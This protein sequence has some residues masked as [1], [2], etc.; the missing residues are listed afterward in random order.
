MPAC[1]LAWAA[2]RRRS[3]QIVGTREPSSEKVGRP[4]WAFTGPR[5]LASVTQ[6]AMQRLDII[7]VGALSGL[8]DAA[9]YAA[10][11]RFLVL[12]G[13]VSGAV[14]TAVQPRL[15]EALGRSDHESARDLYATST[16]WLLMLSWP[17]YLMLIVFAPV[18]VRVFGEEYTSGAGALVIICASML[19]A[20]ACGTVD[21][22]LNM[23]G[24]TTWNLYNVI[25]AFAVNLSLDILLIPHLG[26]VGAAIGW[27]AAIVTANLVPLS[28]IHFVLHLHPFGSATRT[29]MAISLASFAV[30][31]VAA[32]LVIPSGLVAL[33]IAGLVGSCIYVV[34]LVVSRERLRLTELLRARGNQGGS[35][36]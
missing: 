6:L 23:A 29:A 8:K 9:I 11:T 5:A 31:P 30:V 10:V 16:A 20:T 34:L 26:L 7:L 24:K 3:V 19:V 17:I 25:L 2:W 22:V 4:F 15:G 1:A 21:M 35:S 36:P 12:G 18:V 27:A 33:V 14:S 32:S 28:Q 13:M